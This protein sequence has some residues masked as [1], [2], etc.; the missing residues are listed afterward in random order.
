[1]NLSKDLGVT[2]AAIVGYSFTEG[3]SMSDHSIVLSDLA[4][5]GTRHR[6][7]LAVHSFILSVEAQTLAFAITTVPVVDNAASPTSIDWMSA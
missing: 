2:G 4:A 7:S 5:R 1:V 6:D 3:M